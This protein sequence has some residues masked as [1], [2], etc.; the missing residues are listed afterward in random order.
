MA[1]YGSTNGNYCDGYFQSI[2][3]DENNKSREE[4]RQQVKSWSI[5]LT[6]IVLYFALPTVSRNIFDAIKC[7]A[8]DY[9][10]Q[11]GTSLSYLMIDME[12]Q[13]D[14]EFPEYS[15]IT[16]IFWTLFIIWVALTPLSFF[17]LLAKIQ[18]AVSSGKITFLADSCHFLW[19]D[20]EPSMLYWDVV[21]TL[22]KI[23]LT[24][25]IMFIDLKEGSNKILRLVIAIIVSTLYLSILLAYR[26]YKQDV[27]FYLAFLSNFL[28]LCCFSSGIILKHCNDDGEDRNEDDKNYAMSSCASFVGG[29]LDSYRA[30]V[31]VVVLTIIMLIMTIIFIIILS[32]IKIRAPTVKIISKKN[33]PNLELPKECHFH[34]FM[35]H[36]W[37]TGQATTHAIVRKTQAIFPG[38][39][40]W[41]DVDELDDISKLEESIE[42]SAIIVIFYSKGYF[43]SKNCRRE[44]Y[45]AINK[46]KP[47]IVLYEGGDSTIEEMR[48]ECALFCKGGEDDSPAPQVI[49][50]KVLGHTSGD[51]LNTIA[52]E[53]LSVSRN[54]SAAALS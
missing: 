31:F 44:L 5:K 28:I 40:I 54:F 8:F 21:D 33:A 48:K 6:I 49:L 24:G 25:C 12:I 15:S 42:D 9:D 3:K 20:Y 39:K 32:I 18:E 46:N 22:H 52:I 35:S 43:K 19:E 11:E 36:V 13:C 10:D 16:R 27:N 23:F 51:E 38:L 1:I 29:S 4:I 30:S 45:C 7:C 37:S 53:W 2:L 47:I 26:P 34:I 41:L 17:V 14:T 50:E